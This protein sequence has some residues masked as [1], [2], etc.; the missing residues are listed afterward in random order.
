MD[1]SAGE[2]TRLLIALKGDR[3]EAASR[4]FDLLYADCTPSGAIQE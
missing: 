4:L 3:Q 2:V 1:E